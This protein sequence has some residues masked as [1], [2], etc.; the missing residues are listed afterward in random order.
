V[1][2][3]ENG[4]PPPQTVA[5][6]PSNVACA[7]RRGRKAAGLNL[8]NLKGDLRMAAGLPVDKLAALLIVLIS[9]PAL[10][11]TAPMG[12]A[13][14]LQQEL[15]SLEPPSGGIT[16]QLA[17]EMNAALARARSA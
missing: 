1:Y 16:D 8:E 17:Q 15:R 7:E 4:K 10:P 14:V 3:A 12:K 9:P 5:D 13:V 11:P 6:A 2:L